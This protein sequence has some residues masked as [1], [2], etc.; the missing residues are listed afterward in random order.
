MDSIRPI[1]PTSGEI[2]LAEDRKAR[3][4]KVKILGQVGELFRIEA[5]SP[6]DAGRVASGAEVISDYIHYLN[7]GEP[8]RA[9]KTREV[10][11]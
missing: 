1:D 4:V 11:P 6:D 2:F 9:V 3:L 8:I 10:K 5:L 7:D